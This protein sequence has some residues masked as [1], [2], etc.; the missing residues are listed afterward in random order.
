MSRYTTNSLFDRRL[1]S[2]PSLAYRDEPFRWQKTE[3][4]RENQGAAID[5]SGWC[6]LMVIFLI[7]EFFRVLRLRR[8]TRCYVGWYTVESRQLGSHWT[9]YQMV[10]LFPELYSNVH[11]SITGAN[12][13]VPWSVNK[14]LLPSCV[15]FLEGLIFL[16]SSLLIETCRFIMREKVRIWRDIMSFIMSPRETDEVGEPLPCLFLFKLIYLSTLSLTGLSSRPQLI[17][18]FLYYA[19]SET[20]SFH[21]NFHTRKHAL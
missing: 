7:E 17:A 21:S 13:T 1:D 19:P 16:G 18:A 4:M 2:A 5:G 9:T 14:S 20:R 8:L 3:E 15:L 10:V 12:K 11:L 6:S